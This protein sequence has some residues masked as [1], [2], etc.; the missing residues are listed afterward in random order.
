V[1]T[2][3]DTDGLFADAEGLATS[4]FFGAGLDQIE[5]AAAALTGPVVEGTVAVVGIPPGLGLGVLS[6][7]RPGPVLRPSPRPWSPSPA[8]LSPCWPAWS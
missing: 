4:A 3:P 2:A 5:V 8:L 6:I 7:R 1:L